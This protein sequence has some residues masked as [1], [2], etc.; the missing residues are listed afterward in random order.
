EGA[1]GLTLDTHEFTLKKGD[2]VTVRVTAA[3][4][5]VAKN[6][7]P[8]RQA[9]EYVLSIGGA[10]R[11]NDQN[12]DIRAAADLPREPFR[13]THVILEGNKQ[14][15][16][17]GLANFKDCKNLTE[18]N[19]INTPVQDAGLANLKDCRKLR[20]LYLAGTS[21]TD[22][23]LAYFKDCKDLVHLRLDM[24][25]VTDAGLAYFKDCKDLIHVPVDGTAV[26]DAG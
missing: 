18:L 14:V 24:T 10:V 9:T 23:G 7:D 6:V 12:Q 11:V 25:K 4:R 21:V 8:D 16:D 5:A 3:P 20:G 19:L 13:L 17:A 26:T 15:T 22:A 2:Q 1:D